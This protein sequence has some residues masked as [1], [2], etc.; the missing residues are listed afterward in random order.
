MVDFKTPPC[1]NKETLLRSNTYHTPLDWS[2]FQ[3][4][5]FFHFK[6]KPLIS[7]CFSWRNVWVSVTMKKRNDWCFSLFEYCQNTGTRFSVSFSCSYI[8][9][10]KCDVQRERRRVWKRQR[11]K[12]DKWMTKNVY[13][14]SLR[15]FSGI[16]WQCIF[17]VL[18]LQIHVR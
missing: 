16:F 6:S 4:R 15:N 3:Y 1:H 8:L 7:R 17:I 5:A 14:T 11:E 13:L 10:S 12:N 9:V 2:G 18:Q